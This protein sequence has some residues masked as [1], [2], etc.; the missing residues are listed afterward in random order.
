MEM[1]LQKDY[2]WYFVFKSVAGKIL[3]LPFKFQIKLLPVKQV[4]FYFRVQDLP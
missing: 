1:K 2:T 4:P 3:P